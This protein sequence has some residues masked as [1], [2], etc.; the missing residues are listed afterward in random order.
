MLL[1]SVP[2]T[3][4]DDALGCGRY[5]AER[6][7]LGFGGFSV[8]DCCLRPR[9]KVILLLRRQGF[10]HLVIGAPVKSCDEVLM[11][12]SACKSVGPLLFCFLG[13]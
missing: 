7:L 5:M 3:E 9:V 1:V 12:W 6:A 11:V 13:H 8:L 10:L 2:S 4:P